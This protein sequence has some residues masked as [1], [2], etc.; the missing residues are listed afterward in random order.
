M[1]ANCGVA[2]VVRAV[3][4]V[5]APFMTPGAGTAQPVRGIARC[6]VRGDAGQLRRYDGFSGGD[7]RRGAIYDARCRNG[8]TRP[9]HCARRC[10]RCFRPIATLRRL[11][12]RHKCRPY[13]LGCSSA[14]L[15]RTDRSD[16]WFGCAV[17][18][19]VRAVMDVGA[20]FMTPGAGTAQPV[21]GVVR[22]VVRDD[23]GQLRR[24]D[25]YPGDTSV[26]PT[27]WRR[28]PAAL[29]RLSGRYKCRPYVWRRVWRPRCLPTR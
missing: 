28:H 2:S 24:C 14:I 16:A 20:P 6:G 7:G 18:S 29:R 22:G 1:P 27:F 3:M 21:R 26:A 13:V 5:G 9:R 12:G 10:V 17:A 19:V 8:T 23:A 11:S 15:R 25:G 4:D